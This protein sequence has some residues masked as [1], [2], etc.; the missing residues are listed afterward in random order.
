MSICIDAPRAA[1][2]WTDGQLLQRDKGSSTARLEEAVLVSSLANL[3][4]SG[5]TSSRENIASSA[6]GQKCP[7]GGCCCDCGA[8]MYLPYA[9]GRHSPRMGRGPSEAYGKAQALQRARQFTHVSTS[10]ERRVRQYADVTTSRERDMQLAD[11][12]PLQARRCQGRL[13]TCGESSLRVFTASS[14]LIACIDTVYVQ[15][16][17]HLRTVVTDSPQGVFPFFLFLSRHVHTET[18]FANARKVP[19]PHKPRA[20]Y[21]EANLWPKKHLFFADLGRFRVFC[22]SPANLRPPS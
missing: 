11:E 6:H 20:P 22:L 18:R 1:S 4:A 7:N 10:R 8:S 5:G 13:L 9:C 19:E 16:Q 14:G 3:K 15:V 2:R 21:G 17:A 12:R